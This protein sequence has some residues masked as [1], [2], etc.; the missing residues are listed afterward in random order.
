MTDFCAFEFKFLNIFKFSCDLV[1]HD[2][3]NFE[4]HIE[5]TYLIYNKIVVLLYV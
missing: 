2:F 4:N 1:F 3:I 5:N